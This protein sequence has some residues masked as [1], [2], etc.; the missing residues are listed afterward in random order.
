[1]IGKTNASGG[2]MQLCPIEDSSLEL[3]T[4]GYIGNNTGKYYCAYNVD[5]ITLSLPE[6]ACYLLIKTWGGTSYEINFYHGC[7]IFIPEGDNNEVIAT[8][9]SGDNASAILHHKGGEE[10]IELSAIQNYKY[11]AICIIDVK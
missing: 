5:S 4:N 10:R 8:I 6:E 11:W 7:V 2:A 9:S 3:P 1:M